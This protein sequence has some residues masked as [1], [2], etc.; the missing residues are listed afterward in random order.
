MSDIGKRG[1]AKKVFFHQEADSVVPPYFEKSHFPVD[2][3][4]LLSHVAAVLLHEKCKYDRCEVV[5]IFSCFTLSRLGVGVETKTTK[6]QVW[7]VDF[8]TT[9]LLFTVGILWIKNISFSTSSVIHCLPFD[10][11]SLFSI[12]PFLRWTTLYSFRCTS[13][14]MHLKF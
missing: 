5:N 1:E 10:K 8:P 11:A 6:D 3:P 9:A 4:I 7:Q 12:F 14:H 13:T 2:N